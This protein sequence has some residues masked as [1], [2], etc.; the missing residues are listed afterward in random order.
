[1]VNLFIYGLFDDAVCSLD[2]TTT[3]H[4]INNELEI[5][6]RKLSWPNLR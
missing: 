6:G 1:M 3:N 5:Y 4:A 2:C